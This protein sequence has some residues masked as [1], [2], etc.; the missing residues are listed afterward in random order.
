MIGYLMKMAKFCFI[1]DHNISPSFQLDIRS[2]KTGD[3]WYKKKEVYHNYVGCYALTSLFIFHRI[4]I[5][6][7]AWM[8]N[9]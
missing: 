4:L 3:L 6:S 8:N 1:S 9:K 5:S 7:D 2:D